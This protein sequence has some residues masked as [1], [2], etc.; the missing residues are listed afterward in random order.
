LSEASGA[1]EVHRFSLQFLLTEWEQVVDAWQL[2]SWESYRDVVRL[3]RKTR[4]QE[5]QRVILWS[6]FERVRSAL[7]ARG[8]VTWPEIF[9][10]VASK[11]REGAHPPFEFVVVDEAQDASVPQLRFLAA[12]G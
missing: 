12:L 8:L 7:K 4:L 9:S 2:E 6:I 11:I 1:A 5:A 3:G 10:R